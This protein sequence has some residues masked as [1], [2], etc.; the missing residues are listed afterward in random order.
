MQCE[1]KAGTGVGFGTQHSQVQ[2][3]NGKPQE[4]EGRTLI[5]Y[6]L[7]S[8]IEKAKLSLASLEDVQLH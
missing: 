3:S 6:E 5:A 1:R 4:G 8:S 2:L 7:G